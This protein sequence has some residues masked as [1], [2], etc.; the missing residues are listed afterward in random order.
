MSGSDRPH[1]AAETIQAPKRFMTFPEL[2][3]FLE[4]YLEVAAGKVA[5]QVSTEKVHDFLLAESGE[6]NDLF[7]ELV[8]LATS[9]ELAFVDERIKSQ[10]DL[11]DLIRN[12]IALA[13]LERNFRKTLLALITR[14]KIRRLE[15]KGGYDSLMEGFINLKTTLGKEK[16]EQTERKLLKETKESDKP[17]A[18]VAYIDLDKFGP[19]NN[20]YGHLVGDQ[21]L[22]HAA[23]VI[24]DSLGKNRGDVLLRDGGE[25]MAILFP[26]TDEQR[27]CIVAERIRQNLEAKPVYLMQVVTLVGGQE[28]LGPPVAISEELYQERMS[29]NGK[30][31]EEVGRGVRTYIP[32]YRDVGNVNR[33]IA[34]LKIPMTA[35]IGVAQYARLEK[36]EFE[37]TKSAA[38]AQMYLAKHNGRNGL[39]ASGERVTPE[40]VQ[41]TADVIATEVSKG[42]AKRSS[43]PAPARD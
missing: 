37:K 11:E 23:K 4:A 34:L 33:Q 15:Q 43:I 35:S 17:Y 28:K 38:D 31:R 39:Y 25:E 12:D 24:S 9:E 40:T 7:Y 13:L 14:E 16:F 10:S 8:S 29:L 5:H 32:D 26:K 21:T 2:E 41:E 3:G 30:L 36:G 6:L 42:R 1:S 20:E 27:A 22:R 18:S 19:V